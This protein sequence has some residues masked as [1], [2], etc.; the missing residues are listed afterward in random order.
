[1]KRKTMLVVIALIYSIKCLA[2]YEEYHEFIDQ[3]SNFTSKGYSEYLKYLQQ[4][5]YHTFISYLDS[6]KQFAL[7]DIDYVHQFLFSSLESNQYIDNL[8]NIS[9]VTN[10]GYLNFSQYIESI[11]QPVVNP[12]ILDENQSEN[13][14]LVDIDKDKKNTRGLLNKKFPLGLN[15]NDYSVVIKKN[16]FISWRENLAIGGLKATANILNDKESYKPDSS[17]IQEFDENTGQECLYIKKQDQVISSIKDISKVRLC[18]D[19]VVSFEKPNI[20]HIAKIFCESYHQSFYDT[21]LCQSI[22]ST[23]KPTIRSLVSKIHKK[24]P[25][26]SVTSLHQEYKVGKTFYPVLDTSVSLLE[27][28]SHYVIFKNILRENQLSL[29][30]TVKGSKNFK[31]VNLS[32]SILSLKINYTFNER[33]KWHCENIDRQNSGVTLLKIY[34]LQNSKS[35]ALYP[36]LRKFCL[37]VNAE[38]SAYG[39]ELLIDAING[40]ILNEPHKLEKNVSSNTLF[41]EHEEHSTQSH[42]NKILVEHD[43]WL[44]NQNSNLSTFSYN[45]NNP[46]INIKHANNTSNYKTNAYIHMDRFHSLFTSVLPN[47]RKAQF[48]VLPTNLIFSNNLQNEC[49]CGVNYACANGNKLC[50]LVDDNIQTP[51]DTTIT[52]HEYLHILVE[53]YIKQDCPAQKYDSCFAKRASFYSLFHDL[54]D[55]LTME[56]TNTVQVGKHIALQYAASDSIGNTG[57]LPRPRNLDSTNNLLANIPLE[58]DSYKQGIIAGRLLNIAKE[59]FTHRSNQAEAMVIHWI[60]MLRAIKIYNVNK[61]LC[62][63][64]D[65]SFL[66]SQKELMNA[67]WIQILKTED[68]PFIQELFFSWAKEGYNN[69]RPECID[70]KGNNNHYCVD[71]GNDDGSGL[72]VNFG[73]ANSRIKSFNPSANQLTMSVK[74][75]T[76]YKINHNNNL[77][78]LRKTIST[79][80]KRAKIIFLSCSNDAFFEECFSQNLSSKLKDADSFDIQDLDS[81]CLGEIVIDNNDSISVVDRAGLINQYKFGEYIDIN[82]TNSKHLYYQMLTYQDESRGDES[83]IYDDLGIPQPIHFNN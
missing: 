44:D 41:C 40:T 2:I 15:E 43:T 81:Y 10:S 63:S 71:N 70:T 25:N 53:D 7:N 18:I 29:E 35:F 64:C 34:S 82:S 26:L 8:E 13:P 1:M 60:R 77:V 83:Y 32:D 24:V 61:A 42:S 16:M 56:Y 50:L 46:K 12:I 58:R 68:E 39:V 79:C 73:L 38:N 21:E 67:Y 31:A 72:Y 27:T 30:H 6:K 54:A 78:P 52:I 48:P 75:G 20:E 55:H 59:V 14:Q 51:K 62:K 33:H 37:P 69:I 36:V 57:S 47:N 3:N 22:R 5:Q 9:L 74:S 65:L 76:R 17:F 66:L 49:Q 11:N 28:D 4:N 80:N 19:R 45:A 23:N